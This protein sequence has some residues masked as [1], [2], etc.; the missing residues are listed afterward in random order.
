MLKMPARPAVGLTLWPCC[1]PVRLPTAHPTPSPRDLCPGRTRGPYLAPKEHSL[2]VFLR[3]DLRQPGAQGWQCRRGPP[4]GAQIRPGRGE[5]H[6]GDPFRWC[7][8]QS[9]KWGKCSLRDKWAGPFWEERKCTWT[10]HPG[11]RAPV[12]QQLRDGSERKVCQD[13]AVKSWDPFIPL[14]GS[15]EPQG[16]GLSTD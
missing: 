7:S 3:A 8:G 16:R 5:G 9:R 12:E 10:G 14:A 2:V 11:A 13:L 15:Q 6:A 4:E 1:V